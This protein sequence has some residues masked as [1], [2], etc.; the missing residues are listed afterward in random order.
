MKILTKMSVKALGANPARAKTEEKSVDLVR[1][2]GIASGLVF[3]ADPKTGDIQT[4]ISGDFEG[5]N[6][7][8]G[9][10]FRSGI[11]WLPGGIQE[12]LINAVDSGETD[13]NDKPVY[14]SVRFGFTISAVPAT[15]PIGYSYAAE[16][17][18]D[19]KKDDPLAD[20]REQLPALPAPAKK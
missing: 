3:K 14:N 2:Y 15:N 18:I 7:E 19:A 9:E 20:L 6:L 11:L 4:A 12:L 13:K 17:L 5:V 10:V 8:S 16:Q 1:I